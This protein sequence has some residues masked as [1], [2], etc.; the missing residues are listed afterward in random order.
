[1][2]FGLSFVPVQL[3]LGFT[4]FHICTLFVRKIAFSERRE[5]LDKKISYLTIIQRMRVGYEVR[6][7]EWAIII[8]YPTDVSGIIVLLKTKHWIFRI[9]FSTELYFWPF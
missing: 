4:L 3:H 9:L 7:T 1:M 8:S 5:L 6:S 2:K